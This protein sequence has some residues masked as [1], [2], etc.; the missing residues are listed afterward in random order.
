MCSVIVEDFYSGFVF[1]ADA[2]L[3]KAN[4]DTFQAEIPH[5]ECVAVGGRYDKYVWERLLVH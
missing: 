1:R 4:A 3:L 5:H 2:V